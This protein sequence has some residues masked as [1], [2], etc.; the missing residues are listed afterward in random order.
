[1]V[2]MIPI[3][4]FMLMFLT[5]FVVKNQAMAKQLRNYRHLAKSAESKSRFAFVTLNSLAEQIQKDLVSQLES[6]HKR[7][8]I[9][10][11]NYQRSKAIFKCFVYVVIQ[12]CEH[13]ST[14]EEALNRALANGETSLDEIK[15]FVSELPAEIRVPWV[16]ND[17]NSFVTAC[18]NINNH[19]I[20]PTTQKEI[21]EQAS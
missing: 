19:Y 18:T 12:C 10:G 17:V 4:L 3:V 14:V 5:Y 11:E 20:N 1:M 8:L 16:K 13:G 9:K 15:K 21:T 2:A 6:A 7:G